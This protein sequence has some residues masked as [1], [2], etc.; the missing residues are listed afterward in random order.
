MHVTDA[1]VADEPVDPA[2]L[3]PEELDIAADRHPL[4][5]HR[6]HHDHVARAGQLEGSV[7]GRFFATRLFGHR[8]GTGRHKPHCDSPRHQSQAGVHRAHVWHVDVVWL[9]AV[10]G[11]HVDDRRGVDALEFFDCR[12]IKG[13]VGRG[14]NYCHMGVLSPV[15][16]IAERCQ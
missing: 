14:L 15:V 10:P 6:F 5:A 2:L 3:Q 11:E 13:V 9:V 16:R 8:I 12:L 7:F 1:S 4:V